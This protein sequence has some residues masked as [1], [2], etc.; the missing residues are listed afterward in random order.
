MKRYIIPLLLVAS[1]ALS[2]P[3]QVVG[4]EATPGATG[5]RFDV[6]IA[7]GDTG[8]DNYA[9]GWRVE[10]ADGT[11]I[12]DRPL[13]HPHVQEQPFT[14]STSGISIPDGTTRVFIRARTNVE[15]WAEDTTVFA[16]PD[17]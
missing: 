9:D 10:L 5:W 12:G 6:T 8:W 4:I 14:R 15:G 13:A 11:V 3:A 2:D 1:P 17:T 16:V 7:H